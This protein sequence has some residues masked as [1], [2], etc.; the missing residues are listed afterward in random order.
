M[1]DEIDMYGFAELGEDSNDVSFAE[2][3]GEAAYIDVGGVSP[4]SVP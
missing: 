3:V 1:A 2:F 4:I